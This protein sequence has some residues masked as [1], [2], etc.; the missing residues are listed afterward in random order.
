MHVYC[1]FVHICSL[2]RTRVPPSMLLKKRVTMHCAHAWGSRFTTLTLCV[3]EQRAQ[4]QPDHDAACGRVPGPHV[5]SMAVSTT[6]GSWLSMVRCMCVLWLRGG[7]CW[8]GK[9]LAFSR[10]AYVEYMNMVYMHMRVYCT[11]VCVCIHIHTYTYINEDLYFW[12]YPSHMCIRIW[13][14]AYTT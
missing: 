7:S 4:Q 14:I 2:S 13:C 12:I 10:D 9:S 6:C 5:A 1:R 3:P 11:N 8:D